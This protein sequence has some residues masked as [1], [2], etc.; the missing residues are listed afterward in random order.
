MKSIVNLQLKCDSYF[1][2]LD[3]RDD[4]VTS[5]KSVSNTLVHQRHTR[6]GHKDKEVKS[7]FSHYCLIVLEGSHFY[8]FKTLSLLVLKIKSICKLNIKQE[9][10]CDECGKTFLKKESLKIHFKAIHLKVKPCRCKRC[11]ELYR[12]WQALP[13]RQISS[14]ARTDRSSKSLRRE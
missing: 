2:I 7:Q 8:V 1:V 6:T 4:R 10:V 14:A 3:L 11:G 13:Q 12:L 5:C 9:F